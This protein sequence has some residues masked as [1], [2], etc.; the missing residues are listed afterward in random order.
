MSKVF[1]DFLIEDRRKNNLVIHNLPESQ[2]TSVAE[3]SEH[4]AKLFQELVKE[5]FQLHVK[6]MKSFRAGRAIP[7]RHRLLIVTMENV[8]V[9]HDLL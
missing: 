8:E 1:D 4:D 7:G 5:E 6:V 3:H 9:K 2:A